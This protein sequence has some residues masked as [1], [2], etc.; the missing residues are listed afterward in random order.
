MR[1][2]VNLEN[3][4]TFGR[5]GAPTTTT[6]IRLVSWEEGGY[7]V[8]NKPYPQGEIIVGGDSV[9]QGYYKLPSK[10]AEEFFEENGLR[11]FKTGDIGEVHED[12][13]LKIIGKFFS[14]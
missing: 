11:W 14:I 9:S 3:D 5:V 4:L 1:I 10:T 7:R 2:S 8:T 6:E 13:V 12:G